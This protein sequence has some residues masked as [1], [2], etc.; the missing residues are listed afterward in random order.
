MS[1]EQSRGER[2]RRL[3]QLGS[4]LLLAAVVVVALV[5]ASGGGGK[6][7]GRD[8]KRAGGT[9]NAGTL[10]SGIP[11]NGVTL[12]NPAARV[13]LEEYAD[14]QC[15]FCRDYSVQVLPALVKSYVRTGKVKL[16]FRNI[17]FIGPDSTRAA[18]LAAAAGR[19]QKLWP[20]IDSFYASQQA[21]NSGYATDAF[22]RRVATGVP[23]LDVVRA[24]RD[25]TLP[26]VAA[27]LRDSRA[28]AKRAKV[29]STPAF[30]LSAA[31]R[32]PI[33]LNPQS[34]TPEAFAPALDK[35]L[36]G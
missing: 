22:L 35:A 6:K 1:D 2:T 25:R 20:F 4:V 32:A 18:Q 33:V 10:F 12:G 13:T 30:F 17:S 28:R 31:G 27:E 11:Q 9:P 24:F 5:L 7:K 21:E 16:V 34:L 36:S 3:R 8:G 29:Q 23:G 19:Q 26:A 14:L 15:P